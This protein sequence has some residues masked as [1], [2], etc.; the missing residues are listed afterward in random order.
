[1]PAAQY[2]LSPSRPFDVNHQPTGATT[3]DADPV[4]A[5]RHVNA[6]L[7]T[8]MQSQSWTIASSRTRLSSVDATHPTLATL[9]PE[10]S[11]CCYLLHSIEA[12]SHAPSVEMILEM[13]RSVIGGEMFEADVG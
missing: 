2:R 1:M 8:G 6:E 11:V 7:Q 3:L 10:L 4:Q 5:R 9:Q 12:E 13:S